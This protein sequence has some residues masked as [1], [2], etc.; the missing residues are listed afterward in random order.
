M[1]TQIPTS[2]MQLV[3]QKTA[4]KKEENT[5]VF[6]TVCEWNGHRIALEQDPSTCAD[7][8]GL[9]IAS[10]IADLKVGNQL[11]AKGLL[12]VNLHDQHSFSVLKLCL[13]VHEIKTGSEQS[14]KQSGD[15]NRSTG[16][17]SSGHGSA[18]DGSFSDGSSNNGSFNDGS[19]NNGSFNDG[20]SNN[21]SFNDGSSSDEFSS[22]RSSSDRSSSV[23]SSRDGSSRD[24]FSSDG[25]S[26]NRS[27]SNRFS[28]KRS[29]I[30]RADLEHE[31]RTRN[32]SDC[33][34]S[35][36]GELGEEIICDLQIPRSQLPSAKRQLRSKD[37]RDSHY[38]D[39]DTD[40]DDGNHDASADGGSLA[41]VPSTGSLRALAG[42]A[43][44][45][46]RSS[47]Y[48]IPGRGDYEQDAFFSF[49]G[50]G[51]PTVLVQAIVTKLTVLYT[52]FQ[53]YS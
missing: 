1:S 30:K 42:L 35:S 9:F 16:N 12:V 50:R 7:V 20:S 48:F 17:R 47:G 10:A 29:T 13:H 33:D 27:S 21:R 6:E 31:T 37:G 4:C 14:D 2:W 45:T 28:K 36:E 41:L 53:V 34:K 5:V 18:S 11:R 52:L 46:S 43:G 22:D 25:S 49:N 39:G 44:S 19:S 51:Q 38:L 15:S 26:S 23:K 24:G 8:T 32:T 3:V 40:D